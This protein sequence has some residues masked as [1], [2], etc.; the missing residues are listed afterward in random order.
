MPPFSA[1]TCRALRAAGLFDLGSDSCV[2]IDLVTT[3][4]LTKAT[5]FRENGS[6]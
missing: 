1:G 6:S 3:L 5:C 2:S 4:D